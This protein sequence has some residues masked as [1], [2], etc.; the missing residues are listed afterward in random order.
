MTNISIRYMYLKAVVRIDV[1][2]LIFVTQSAPFNST[3]KI[4]EDFQLNLADFELS[5]SNGE[6]VSKRKCR[7]KQIDRTNSS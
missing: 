1:A 2:I 6:S 4:G 7:T 3:K 5:V